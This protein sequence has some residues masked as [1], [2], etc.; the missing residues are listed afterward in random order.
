MTAILRRA[1]AAA[2]SA[3]WSRGSRV[4]GLGSTGGA[5]DLATGVKED[6]DFL[7]QYQP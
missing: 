2:R 5:E 4:M 1:M 3:R 6:Q 7:L